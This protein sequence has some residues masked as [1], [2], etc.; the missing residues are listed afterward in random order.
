MSSAVQTTAHAGKPPKVAHVKKGLPAEAKANLKAD[1][2]KPDAE[3]SVGEVI[4]GFDYTSILEPELRQMAQDAAERIAENNRTIESKVLDTGRTLI[5]FKEAIKSKDK[6]FGDWIKAAC[7]FSYKTALNYMAVAREFGDDYLL[8]SYIPS[9]TLYRVASGKDLDEARS[10]VLE[11]A[12]KGNPLPVTDVE[13]LISQAK[14]AHGDG[15]GNLA[16]IDTLEVRRTAAV[17][18]MAWLEKND[19]YSVFLALVREAGREFT[20]ALG[21][22]AKEAV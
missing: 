4:T 11:A 17:K 12:K 3:V 19:D 20:I 10:A 6:L 18:A 5:A 13:K 1:I 16:S 21:N 22:A 15:A 2:A 8:L 14:A 7:P 9:Q